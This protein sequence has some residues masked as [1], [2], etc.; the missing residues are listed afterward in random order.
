MTREEQK[1]LLDITVD[2]RIRAI[3]DLVHIAVKNGHISDDVLYI[4]GR[5]IRS[6]YVQGYYDALTEPRGLLHIETDYQ[7]PEPYVD[8]RIT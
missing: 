3:W 8:K 4:I 7:I 2:M 5:L 6:A 1:R